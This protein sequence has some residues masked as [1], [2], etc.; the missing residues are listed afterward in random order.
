[1]REDGRREERRRDQQPPIPARPIPPDE[2]TGDQREHEDRRRPV[3]GDLL[4]PEVHRA[5]EQVHERDSRRGG[6]GEN[7][8]RPEVAAA[9]RSGLLP[10]S[11]GSVGPQPLGESP[12]ES[13]RRFVFLAHPAE[14]HEEGLVRREPGL[15]ETVRPSAQFLLALRVPVASAPLGEEFLDPAGFLGAG[16][17]A[18]PSRFALPAPTT[19]RRRR[20]SRSGG[21]LLHSR[22]CVRPSGRPVRRTAPRVPGFGRSKQPPGTAAGLAGRRSVTRRARRTA[23]TPPLPSRAVRPANRAVPTG[24]RSAGR[25]TDPATDGNPGSGRH[26]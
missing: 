19:G 3:V 21:R 5:D 22:E 16:H 2:E 8:R 12:G 4:V 7:E 11:G 25:T 26:R 24:G 6:D 17:G 9:L 18:P 20:F 13:A 14:R 1:M 15:Q 23:V 10:G